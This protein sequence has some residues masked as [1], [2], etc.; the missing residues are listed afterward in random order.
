MR[1]PLFYAK[2][3]ILCFALVAAA[4]GPK[5][6]ASS[7]EAIENA[8]AM[9]TTE[10]KIDYLISQAEAFYKSEQYKDAMESARYVLKNLEKD[11]QEAKEILEKARKEVGSVVDD[12][13]ESI[14]KGVEG[15][16]K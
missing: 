14:Q 12:M 16:K 4:C 13:K 2:A 10:Q 1:K 5:K 3:C 11:S 15:F 8:K 6:A 7:E 9:E